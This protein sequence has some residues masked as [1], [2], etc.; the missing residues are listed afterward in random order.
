MIFRRG[1]TIVNEQ[2]VVVTPVGIGVEAFWQGMKAGKSGIARVTHL[3]RFT[4]FGV[5]AS[6]M[7]MKDAGL[8]THAFDKLVVQKYKD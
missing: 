7:A 6:A 4:A 2:R 3:D 8:E 1:Q 5:S